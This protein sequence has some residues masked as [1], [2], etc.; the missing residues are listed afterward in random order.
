[1]F[2]NFLCYILI[3]LFDVFGVIDLIDYYLSFDEPDI[4]DPFES[5]ES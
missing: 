5:S 4:F 2:T 3:D 1:M